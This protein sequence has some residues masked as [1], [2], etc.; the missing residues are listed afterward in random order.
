MQGQ[1]QNM[2]INSQSY[3][4]IIS[5]YFFLL[6]FEELSLSPSGVRF[7]FNSTKFLIKWRTPTVPLSVQQLPSFEGPYNI[8]EILEI[9]NSPEWSAVE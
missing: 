4:I 3:A 8:S 6:N 2:D 7:S 9:L 5:E 1:N